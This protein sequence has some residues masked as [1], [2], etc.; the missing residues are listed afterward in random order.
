LQARLLPEPH[1]PAG[2]LPQ[3]IDTYAFL[4]FLEQ[5]NWIASAVEVERCAST[6]GRQFSQIRFPSS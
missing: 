4:Q 2:L 1:P 5:K 3:G 6:A